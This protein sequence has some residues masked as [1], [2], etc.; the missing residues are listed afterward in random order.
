MGENIL[1]KKADLLVKEIYRVSKSFPKEEIYGLT[2]QLRRAALSVPLNIIEGFARNMRN[3][4]RRF[5]EIAYA[6]LKETEYLLYFAYNEKYL[7][8]ADYE[9]LISLSEEIGKM[10][11]SSIRTIKE[12]NC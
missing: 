5:L 4:N 12:K 7:A 9:E 2:S 3:E 8:T 1:L 6:S 11:W 10:L